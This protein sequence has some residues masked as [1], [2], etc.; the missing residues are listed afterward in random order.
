MDGEAVKGGK[1]VH[2]T[3]SQDE[4]MQ[5]SLGTA[6]LAREWRCKSRQ[7]WYGQDG[8]GPAGLGAARQAMQVEAVGAR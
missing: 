1:A 6:R 5:G 4:A 2:G 8:R 7:S 3:A